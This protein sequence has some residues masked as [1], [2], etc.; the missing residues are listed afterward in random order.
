MPDQVPHLC[1]AS[2]EK[3]PHILDQDRHHVLLVLGEISADVRRQQHVRHLPQRARSIERRAGD[4]VEAGARDASLGQLVAP[5]ALLLR[6][7][8]W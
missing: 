5:L 3:Q 7:T 6:M 8:I 4:D 2:G 1:A